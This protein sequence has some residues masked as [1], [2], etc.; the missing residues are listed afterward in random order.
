MAERD[1]FEK[2]E[3]DQE[4]PTTRVATYATNEADYLETR[5]C[6]VNCPNRP[7]LWPLSLI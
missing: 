6:S 5:W 1:G 2:R 4:K 7:D 3:E